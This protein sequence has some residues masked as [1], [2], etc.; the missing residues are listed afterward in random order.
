MRTV[1]RGATILA[2]AGEHG[3]RPFVDDIAIEAARIEAIGIALPDAPAD[4]TIKGSGRLIIP[5]L[6]NGHMHSS[7]A[8]FNGPSGDREGEQRVRAGVRR[9]PS[10]LHQHGYRDQSLWQ[11]PAGLAGA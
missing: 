2:M 1:I 8:L 7:E 4:R 11:R 6:I 5:G 10:A 3:T 9:D